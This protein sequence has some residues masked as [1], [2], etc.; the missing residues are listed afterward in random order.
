[1]SVGKPK[2]AHRVQIGRMPAEFSRGNADRCGGRL[3]WDEA[4]E[5]RFFR[6]K[7]DD[8]DRF[9][10][11]AEETCTN[12]QATTCRSLNRLRPDWCLVSDEFAAAGYN[13]LKVVLAGCRL[14]ILQISGCSLK[15]S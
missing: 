13:L 12:V 5:F 14:I 3:R 4:N 11:I 8:A 1:M 6:P 9:I 15:G 2:R 10:R 7:S